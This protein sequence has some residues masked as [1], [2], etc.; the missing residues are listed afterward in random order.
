[1]FPDPALFVSMRNEQKIITYLKNW[2]WHR[3][4]FI[5]QVSSAASSARPL[6]TQ[7]WRTFLFSVSFTKHENLM[8]A[9]F[10]RWQKEIM[11]ILEG[12]L[13]GDSVGIKGDSSAKAF[14][15]CD[16]VMSLNHPLD[17][18]TVQPI[19]WELYKLNF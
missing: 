2:L 11:D 12:C 16:E 4:I 14:K 3:H 7:T 17:P 5:Y 10:Q 19:F 15:F 8:D 1:M 18:W 13:H 6:S 9:A